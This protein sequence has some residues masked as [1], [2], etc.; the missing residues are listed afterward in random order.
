[1]RIRYWIAAITFLVI[2]LLIIFLTSTNN[3]IININYPIQNNKTNN[4]I[5]QSYINDSPKNNFTPSIDPYYIPPN[6]YVINNINWSKYPNLQKG[7]VLAAYKTGPN[8]V[9][10]YD[11]V[12]VQICTEIKDTDNKTLID[13][14]L[15]GVAKEAKA[16]YGS[17]S[18]IT[19]AGT[20]GG[21]AEYFAEILPYN[22]TV[23]L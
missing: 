15:S 22:D 20:M 18:G 19:I 11:F 6:D 16:F 1:M 21:A 5:N 4:S 9:L 23:L 10:N 12:D 8:D 14:Q 17:A 13:E 7:Y 3:N 2:V